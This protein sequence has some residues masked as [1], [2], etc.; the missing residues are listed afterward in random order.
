MSG[1]EFELHFLS[2]DEFELTSME[3]ETTRYRRGQPYVPTAEELK[4]FA[5][6]YTNDQTGPPST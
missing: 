5:G 4:A 1:D 6:E 2:A 3:G